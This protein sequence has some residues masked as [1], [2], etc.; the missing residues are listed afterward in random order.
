MA[1]LVALEAC[2]RDPR[3]L[4]LELLDFPTIDQD[5]L[6]A[7]LGVLDALG[8]GRAGVRLRSLSVKVRGWTEGQAMEVVQPLVDIIDAGGLPAFV[9][10]YSDI[11]K[12]EAV[13]VV[14]GEKQVGETELQQ[15]VKRAAGEAWRASW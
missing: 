6:P 1:E 4:Q 3:V 13:K 9:S 5:A 8:H 10:L 7:L 14:M 11:G 15:A 2:L 12:S